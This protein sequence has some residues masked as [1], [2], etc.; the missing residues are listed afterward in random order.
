MTWERV[1]Y[2]VYYEKKNVMI[3]MQRKKN[4]SIHIRRR[5]IPLALFKCMVLNVV[6]VF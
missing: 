6:I 1:H 4:V 2:G 5:N 3:M